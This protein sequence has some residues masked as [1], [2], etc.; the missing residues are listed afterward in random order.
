MGRF[1]HIKAKNCSPTW[2]LCAINC[3]LLWRGDDAAIGQCDL[4][5][6]AA[7]AFVADVSVSPTIQGPNQHLLLALASLL[8]AVHQFT[9]S[10]FRKGIITAYFLA[11][12]IGSKDRN[13]TFAGIPIVGPV[14][15]SNESFQQYIL[16]RPQGSTMDQS[17]GCQV[18]YCFPLNGSGNENLEM[19]G[20]G[21]TKANMLVS[22]TS[23]RSMS[24]IKRRWGY[25]WW[26][27]PIDWANG[28]VSL[29][30]LLMFD[31]EA[32]LWFFSIWKFGFSLHTMFMVQ[33][34]LDPLDPFMFVVAFEGNL[35][36]A[37]TDC[38]WSPGMVP[39][40]R[41]GLACRG[42]RMFFL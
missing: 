5:H 15:R 30:K 2:L 42:L 9:C 21:N 23:S 20:R 41:P 27:C 24:S 25:L 18:V 39:R 12:V 19:D 37:L 13:L 38:G 35:D 11:N 6:F 33:T 32:R 22:F 8:R 17:P 1:C 4:S 34:K 10:P 36:M 7:T 29:M 14:S 26:N 31:G 16:C 40:F 28:V 3:L